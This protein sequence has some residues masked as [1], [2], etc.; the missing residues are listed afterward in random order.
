M[1]KKLIQFDSEGHILGNANIVE[2]LAT[3]GDVVF[4]KSYIVVGENLQ[5][6]RIHAS[7]DLDIMTDVYAES[8]NVNGNLLVKGDIEADELTCHGTFVCMG[9]V[10]VKKLN[11]ESYAMVGSVVGENVYSGGDLFVKTTIDTSRSFVSEGVV[12][13]GEGILGD[14]SF[15]AKAAIANEYFEF[16]GNRKSKIFEISEMEFSSADEEQ[17]ADTEKMEVAKATRLFNGVL[18]KSLNEWN[19]FEKEEL[20]A[21]LHEIITS[22]YDLHFLNRIINKVIKISYE[23]EIENFRDYLY[24]LCARNIFPK[25]LAEHK[26]FEYVLGKMFPEATA[27]V[28]K[29]E[30]KASNVGEFSC[31]L[32]ILDVYQNQLPISLEEG[33][34]KIF[35]SIGLRYSTVKHAWRNYNEQS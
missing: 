12:V 23:Q 10:R 35:S 13:A 22:M 21:R 27:K 11:V 28:D 30:Y 34:D 29:M 25:E 20:N 3:D 19:K 17:A 1:S 9:E 5:A 2:A 15:Q 4:S 31:S 7:Y 6:R 24:I 8:V 32:H 26:E 14:G 33:A 18:V 16:S